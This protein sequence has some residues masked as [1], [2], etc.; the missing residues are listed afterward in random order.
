MCFDG[1][2]IHG[3]Y[4]RLTVTDT[5]VGMDD[6]TQ[7]KI[8]DPFF[9]TR[10]VGQGTGLGLSTVFGIVQG[11]EGGIKGTSEAEKGSIF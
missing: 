11:H 8:F 6:E 10:E 3:N 5:G 4:C 1:T 9:T 2:E 7:A